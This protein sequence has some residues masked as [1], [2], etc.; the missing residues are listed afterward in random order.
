MNRTSRHNTLRSKKVFISSHVFILR[1]RVLV[2]TSVTETHFTKRTSHC[3]MR[4]LPYIVDQSVGLAA[5]F[6]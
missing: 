1:D 4:A 6:P 3:G 2:D 5:Q